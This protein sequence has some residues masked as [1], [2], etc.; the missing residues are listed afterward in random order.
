MRSILAFAFA[1]SLALPGT[2]AQA[3]PAM[4][5]HWQ[6]TMTEH[7]QSIPVSF[8]FAAGEAGGDF[9]SETQAATDY[10]LDS[11]VRDGDR[12]TFVLGGGITFHGAL[13]GDTLAGDFTTGDQAG[14][15][16]LHRAQPAALPYDVIPVS[17]ANGDVTLKGTLCIPRTPGRHPAAVLVHGSGPETRW[18]TSRYIAGQL[19]R[20]GVAALV[21]DKRGAGESGGDWRTS[22]F[23]ALARD[24]LAAVD[25]LRARPDIDAAHIGIVGHSQGGVIAPLAAT[26]APDKVSFIVAEDT[27]AGRQ[28]DQDIYRVSH[29]IEGLQLAPADRAEAMRVYGL[30]VDAAHGAV[31]YETFAKA[32]AA[33]QQAS[34]YGW[35]QFPPR[36]SWVWTFGRL[37]GAFDTL[38]VWRQVRAPVLLV[39]GEKDALGPVGESITRIEAALDTNHTPYT[40][41]VAPDAQ[42]NLTVQPDDAGPFFWWRQAPGIIDLMADWVAAQTARGPAANP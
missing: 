29:A 23:E 4:A 39:Y 12:V 7:G 16:A 17:F 8:N 15:F 38:P 37:N 6:G 22:A 42:H 13:S 40:A 32:A 26:L 20:A 36:D 21:Y 24:A 9:T 27:F 11:V 34:W 41:I 30:F 14:S 2:A 25:L 1:I 28:S 10:P 35:M 31:P 19:A 33:D 18:G 5:G 3:A